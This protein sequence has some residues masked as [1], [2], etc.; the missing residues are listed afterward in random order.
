[1]RGIL[2]LIC[3]FLLHAAYGQQLSKE[4]TPSVSEKNF[5]DTIPFDFSDNRIYV[6]AAVN[7]V[8]RKFL[9][10]TGVTHLVLAKHLQPEVGA[11]YQGDSIRDSNGVRQ[12]STIGYLRELRLGKIHFNLA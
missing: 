9:F 1:M 6:S 11:L 10:D 7:G 4:Q 8:E 2:L 5:A 3:S 12:A